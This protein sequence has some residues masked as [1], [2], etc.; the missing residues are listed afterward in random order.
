MKNDRLFSAFIAVALALVITLSGLACLA[1][2]FDLPANELSLAFGCG[3][4]AILA[5]ICMRSPKS[6]L[7][8]GAAAV[9]LLW[10]QISEGNL[11]LSLESLAYRLT[12]IYDLGY[13]WGILRW[14]GA[15]LSAVSC[16][17]ALILLGCII[18]V[19]ICFAVCR[20]RCIILAVALAFL[21]LMLCCVVTD[22]IPH[23]NALVV[24]VMGLALLILPHLIRRT[25]PRTAN[26]VVAIL[27]IPVILFTAVIFSRA[28][29]LS[30]R[31]RAEKLQAW[32][33]ELFPELDGPGIF[34]GTVPND[35]LDLQNL[36]PMLQGTATEL[37]IRTDES[38]ILYLRGRSYDLYT[39]TA[40]DS[41]ADT[42]GE[43]GWVTGLTLNP[44]TVRVGIAGGRH[45]K[46]FSYYPIA[47]DWTDQLADGMMEL[48]EDTA[49]YTFQY[50]PSYRQHLTSG[51]ISTSISHFSPLTKEEREIYLQL[52]D[53]TRAAAEELVS[54]ILSGGQLHLYRDK[55]QKI[56]DFVYNSAEYDLK[57]PAM[58]AD[59][60]DFALWFLEESDSGY[61]THFASA[62]TVL[63]RAAGIPA[64]LVTGYAVNVRSGQVHTVTGEDAHA[65]V[66]YLDLVSGWT[67]LDP[68]PVEFGPISTDPTAPTEAT[69]PTQATLPP[70]EPT[71]P[72]ASTDPTETTAPVTVPTQATDPTQITTRPTAPTQGSAGTEDP[73]EPLDLSWLKDVAL[74]LGVCALVIFQHGLRKTLRRKML[75]KLPPNKQALRCWRY[76]RRGCRMMR[77]APPEEL[78]A[79]ANKAAF[80]QHTLTPEE[81]EQFHAWL[82][83]CKADLLR[84]PI[85]LRWLLKLIFAL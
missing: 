81:L 74:A 42:T 14:S 17:G 53:S 54:S 50:N 8:G 58:P 25:D 33:L 31:D 63:L 4:A 46:Y 59:A 26:R 41:T 44:I 55:V 24:L 66:E 52:P 28:D 78:Q 69:E 84:R 20:R 37:Y 15:D 49:S 40:W 62:A 85:P 18:V 27:L 51:I 38:T 77:H 12:Y 60:D 11:L 82:R 48:P 21:P 56:R 10:W 35:T 47:Q 72:T 5:V 9:V 45:P 75:E 34:P 6:A 73:P 23:T 79:L 32:F 22:T 68:T 61:C 2:A 76:V 16:T 30:F 70:T 65:W 29:E 67:M 39:G 36:G 83:D 3:L 64:R 57:T 7:I 80:S 71:E 19:P 1:T 43:N 13:G